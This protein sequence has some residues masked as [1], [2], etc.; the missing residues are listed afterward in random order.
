MLRYIARSVFGVRTERGNFPVLRVNTISGCGKTTFGQHA[1][2]EVLNL[3]RQPQQNLTLTPEQQT[4]LVSLLENSLQ[5]F[6]DFNGGDAILP[7]DRVTSN[8]HLILPVRLAARGLC[9]QSL[10]RAASNR[11][12]CASW[13]TLSTDVVLDAIVARYRQQNPQLAQ[14]RVLIFVHI[15]EFQLMAPAM[16]PVLTSEDAN[17][18]LKQAVQEIVGYNTRQDRAVVILLLT[19]TASSGM[20]FNITRHTVIPVNLVPFDLDTSILLLRSMNVHP[21]WCELFEFRRLIRDLGGLPALLTTLVE[22]HPELQ[23]PFTPSVNMSS[24]QNISCVIDMLGS[25]MT[26]A[27]LSR[28]PPDVSAGMITASGFETLVEL[29]FANL[30]I[31][32]ETEI[33]TTTVAAL[34][35]RGIIVTTY[36]DDNLP[37]N[38]DENLDENLDDNLP[39][40]LPRSVEGRGIV[41]RMPVAMLSVLAG[42]FMSGHLTYTS[43]AMS[44]FPRVA[45]GD[46][47]A[48]EAFVLFSVASRLNMIRSW[49]LAAARPARDPQADPPIAVPRLHHVLG[50]QSNALRGSAPRGLLN[51]ELD[52]R[53][54]GNMAE[55]QRFEFFKEQHQ[56]ITNRHVVHSAQ[57]PSATLSFSTNA[58]ASDTVTWDAVDILGAGPSHPVFQCANSTTGVD[59]RVAL[60]RVAGGA[61]PVMI[62][63][64][65]KDVSTSRE[66]L[67]SASQRASDIARTLADLDRSALG[68]VYDFVLVLAFSGNATRAW[69]KDVRNGNDRVIVLIGDDIAC[70]CPMF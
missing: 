56:F 5:L 30:P 1:I 41:I 2:S 28:C 8:S 24:V 3:L 51:I 29:S 13:S 35:H 63:F 26:A 53:N 52:L 23:Q 14:Q 31:F 37:Q 46:G 6:I 67:P 19:S 66:E 58:S 38:L 60:R 70:L 15:D 45:G 44:K 4:Y 39:Q 40:N 10:T 9:G 16:S 43:I 7:A 68:G 69:A 20:T 27:V 34:A 36:P 22:R 57:S 49:L 55:A 50:L 18:W 12:F 47:V 25:S 11:I 59:G 48:F 64:Q 65:M 62:L 42:R 21:S 32:E 33:G 54:P 17:H 61:R